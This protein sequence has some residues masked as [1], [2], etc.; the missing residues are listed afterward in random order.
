MIEMYSQEISTH[1]FKFS[2]TKGVT[3]RLR[4][5]KAKDFNY[6]RAAN[7]EKIRRDTYEFVQYYYSN[8]NNENSKLSDDSSLIIS[9]IFLIYR[10]KFF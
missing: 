6:Y 3:V 5:V 1:F 8:V 9:K 2:Q 10:Y 4:H 7:V